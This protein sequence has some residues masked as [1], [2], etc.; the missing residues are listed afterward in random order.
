MSL[1]HHP[2]GSPDCTVSG[3]CDEGTACSKVS[4]KAFADCGRE[5][6]GKETCDGNFVDDRCSFLTFCLLMRG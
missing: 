6:I 5:T 3:C 2:S 1:G 4:Q